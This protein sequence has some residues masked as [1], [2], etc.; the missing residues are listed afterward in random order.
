MPRISIARSDQLAVAIASEVPCGISV[1]PVISS[2][3]DASD[4][5]A[6]GREAQW[7]ERLEKQQPGECWPARLRCSKQ[8]VAKACCSSS[9]IAPDDLEVIDVEADGRVMVRGREMNWPCAAR[10]IRTDDV[11]LAY[12]LVSEVCTPTDLVAADGG[13]G[14]RQSRTT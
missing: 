14:P 4:T 9:R 1:E 8:A 3:A 5:S 13:N 7:L 11:I 6:G 10:T 2:S 12:A